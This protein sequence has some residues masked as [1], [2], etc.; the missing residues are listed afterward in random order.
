MTRDKHATRAKILAAVGSVLTHQG[1]ARFGI[2][3]VAKEAGVDK[4]LIY[5]YFG[6]LDGL[7]MAYAAENPVLFAPPSLTWPPRE[8]SVS[9]AVLTAG[10]LCDQLDELR[11]RPVTL[12]T[13]RWELQDGN[14]LTEQFASAREKIAKEYLARLT[15]EPE[16]YPGADVAAVF[17]FMHAGLTYLAMSSA[18]LD[19][20]Q[21]IDLKS[22]R[23]WKRVEYAIHELLMAYFERVSTTRKPES[24]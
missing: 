9:P 8:K 16:N 21:G 17:A 10:L 11:R 24:E 22:A 20:Y 15:F 23:G 18:K 12:E 13:L 1:F 19:F 14:G 2:N 4:V 5:R 6:G 7:L 3:I